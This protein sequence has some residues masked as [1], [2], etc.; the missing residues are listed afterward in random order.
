MTNR[1]DAVL[2]IFDHD[3]REDDAE[4]LISAIRHLRGVG[5]VKPHVSD[6][7]GSI[8]YSRARLDLEKRLWNALRDEKKDDRR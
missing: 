5:E 6:L 8:A 7:E 3:I 2:V 1:L 4:S